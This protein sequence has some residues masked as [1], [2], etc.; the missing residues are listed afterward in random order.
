VPA[1]AAIAAVGPGQGIE[2]GTGK[3]FAAGAAVSASA[4]NPYLIYKIAFL[5]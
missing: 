2:L 3:M 5:H 4:K 1:S